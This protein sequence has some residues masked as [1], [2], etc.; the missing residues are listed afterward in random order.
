MKR[1]SAF[2][3]LLLGGAA[4]AALPRVAI[5]ARLAPVSAQSFAA[6]LAPAPSL[7]VLPAPLAAPSF[8][9]APAAPAAAA[10]LPADFAAP[11]SAAPSAVLPAAP[12]AIDQLRADATLAA[13]PSAPRVSDE[14]SAQALQAGFDAA[15]AHGSNAAAPAD[16]SPAPLLARLLKIAQLD[17]GGVPERRAAL[18]RAFERML[19]TPTGRAH[20]ERFIESGFPAVVRFEAFEGSR[21][22]EVN[23]RKIF[24]APR[25][26]TEWRDDHVVVRLNLDY[27]GT[28]SEYLEQDLPPTLAH[29]LFGHGPWYARAARE[30][31]LQPFH[32]HELNETNARL[33][34]WLVDFELDHRFEEGGAWSYLTD[35]VA[36]MKYLKLRLPY[37]AVTWSTAEL[38]RPRETLE[39][40]SLAAQAK[41]EHLQTILSNHS[42]WNGVIDFF[43][44][45]KTLAEASVRALRAYM[46]ETARGFEDE[47]AVLHTLIAD[48]DGIVGR[49]NA[50]PDRSS[51]KFLRE[52]AA[53]PLFADLQRETD[54]NTRRLLQQ[55]EG[56]S[57]KFG[58]ESAAAAKEREDHWR[59]QLTFEGLMEMYRKDRERHPEHWQG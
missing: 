11:T 1:L 16:P 19:E 49:M 18:T 3:I 50:E 41:R 28:S 5:E 12:N 8:P 6:S 7:F 21:L 14:D 2:L 40:R 55:V 36:F 37:Y 29:E 56:T 57:A 39:E 43:V 44:S 24:Y 46:A 9:A 10:P 58:D 13:P 30:N 51:E 4:Q 32:H 15:A 42:S 20:A 26:W 45:K 52:A 38:A 31:V 54:E 35:P 17:D 33:V 47:I 59:G 22:F 48:V 27:L 53:H 34:G 25:A 23:G